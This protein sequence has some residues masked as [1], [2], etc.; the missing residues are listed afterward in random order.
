LQSICSSFSVPASSSLLLLAE[1]I[2]RAFG[3]DVELAVGNRGRRKNFVFE[4]IDLQ[5]FPLT[6]GLDDRDGA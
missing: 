4:K 3:S 1:T 6:C 5:N 2:E